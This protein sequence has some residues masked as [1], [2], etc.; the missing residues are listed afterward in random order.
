[1]RRGAAAPVW[2]L[3][4]GAND[5]RRKLAWTKLN[6]VENKLWRCQFLILTVIIVYYLLSN[7]TQLMHPLLQ[8]ITLHTGSKPAWQNS[9]NRLNKRQE[10]ILPQWLNFFVPQKKHHYCWCYSFLDLLLD[11]LQHEDLLENKV[12]SIL[13]QCDRH[14]ENA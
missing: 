7:M 13:V 1:M 11:M 3:G 10:K 4:L 2:S 14:Q 5:A 12:V 9:P 8:H 6:Q